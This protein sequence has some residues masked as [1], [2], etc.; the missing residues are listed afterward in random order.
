[1]GY[2]VRREWSGVKTYSFAALV[3]ERGSTGQ[4]DEADIQFIAV[5][6][7]HLVDLVR[8]LQQAVDVAQGLIY[9]EKVH[10]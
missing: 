7:H 10:R 2:R 5:V 9:K 3:S 8:T 4:G 6:D 1:M